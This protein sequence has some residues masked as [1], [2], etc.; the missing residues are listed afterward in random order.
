MEAGE[1]SFEGMVK[2]WAIKINWERGE[3]LIIHNRQFTWM[4]TTETETKAAF[5]KE[6][7]RHFLAKD[8]SA[9][10]LLRWYLFGY[11]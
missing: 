6:K 5:L 1:G 11:I 9:V 2:K 4:S 7:K 8:I 3:K 10:P